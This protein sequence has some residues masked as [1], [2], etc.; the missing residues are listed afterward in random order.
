MVLNLW[1]CVWKS[2]IQ[3]LVMILHVSFLPNSF[4]NIQLVLFCN[5][6]YSLKYH[7]WLT[8]WN[9]NKM[10]FYFSM[11]YHL[12]IMLGFLSNTK[13]NTIFFI[14]VYCIPFD[15][16]PPSIAHMHARVLLFLFDARWV[17]FLLH[18]V[19]WPL[20][21]NE[22]YSKYKQLTVIY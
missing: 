12:K 3:K 14:N 22:Q 20:E 5:M 15:F 11:L 16:C 21:W 19:P 7:L 17:L 9:N 8:M 2:N 1:L 4:L 18:F 6:P 10:A 13:K